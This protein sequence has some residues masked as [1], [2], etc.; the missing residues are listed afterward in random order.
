MQYQKQA[1]LKAEQVRKHFSLNESN[2][3]F[4]KNYTKNKKLKNVKMKQNKHVYYLESKSISIK[5]RLKKYFVFFPEK[6]MVIIPM[7]A[8]FVIHPNKVPQQHYP[9][10][11]HHLHQIFKILH[12]HHHYIH[13]KK[14][15]WMMNNDKN[16]RL[17]NDVKKIESVE[18]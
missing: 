9:I 18:K 8:H 6:Q 15:I 12:Q 7:R 2:F 5:N 17:L 10:H 11:L 4:R 1:K 14:Q 13:N 16:E 3:L